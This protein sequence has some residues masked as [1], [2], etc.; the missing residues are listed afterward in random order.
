MEVCMEKKYKV[1]GIDCA[2]CAMKAERAVSKVKGVKKAILNFFME[3][4][5]VEVE[6]ENAEAILEEVKKTLL[7]NEPDA[8]IK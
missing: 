3:T 8:I 2:N 1:S 6:D 5:T 7:K 4:L